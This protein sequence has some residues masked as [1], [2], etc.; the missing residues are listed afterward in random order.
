MN[1]SGDSFRS[2][3]FKDGSFKNLSLLPLWE[4]LKQEVEESTIKVFQP[5]SFNKIRI[6]ELWTWKSMEAHVHMF[7]FS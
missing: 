3:P 6:A 2:S 1:I 7:Q 5:S 4:L